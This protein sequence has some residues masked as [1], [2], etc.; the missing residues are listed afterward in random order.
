MVAGFLQF[1]TI[2]CVLQIYINILFCVFVRITV[3]K[4]LSGSSVLV[5]A[6][7]RMQQACTCIDACECVCVCVCMCVCVCV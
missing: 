1:H 5:F 4:I 3:T 7:V 6:D 2:T